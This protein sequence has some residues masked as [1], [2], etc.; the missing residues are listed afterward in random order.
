M[1]IPWEDRLPI[2]DLLSTFVAVN[3]IKK[4]F[5][6]TFFNFNNNLNY[7]SHMFKN[8]IKASCILAA[9]L[10]IGGGTEL[11]HRTKRFRAA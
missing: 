9:L 2:S 5:K 8:L 4:R 11:M 3:H 7:Y 6:N 1:R 10:S